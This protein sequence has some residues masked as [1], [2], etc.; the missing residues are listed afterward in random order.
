[1]A[2]SNGRKTTS[3]NKRTTGRNTTN[4]TARN[5]AKASTK[6]KSVSRKK[7]D[8]YQAAQDSALF[9][10]IGLIVLF[11]VMLLLFCCNFG[12]IGPVGNTVSGVMFGLFG[13][14]AYVAPVLLFLAVAFWFA[15]EG[16]PN[17][18]RKLI[19]GIVLFVMV[20]IV[21][22][23]IVGNAAEMATYNVAM[24]Y[25]G[26]ATNKNGGGIL[27]GSISY[28]LQMYL[29]TIGAVL[30]V[31]L[32]SVISLILLTEKSL[33]SSMKN[34]GARFCE[35]SREDAERRREYAEI[36]R[37]NA[38]IRRESARAKQDELRAKR[39]EER[40]TKEEERRLRQEEAENEKILRMEKKITGVMLD[41]ALVRPEDAGRRD[42]I[43]EIMYSEEEEVKQTDRHSVKPEGNAFDMDKVRIRSA[44]QLT[45]DEA[46]DAWNGQADVQEVSVQRAET[47][48]Q[49][50]HI[51]I[52]KEGVSEEVPATA[53]TR[54]RPV[55]R[56]TA[57]T[58]M[59]GAD[60]QVQKD[61]ASAEKKIP[62]TY[63]FP[64]LSRLQK[65]VAS[66]GD[67]T[68]ELKETAMR[69]QQTLHTFG[70]KVTITDI[71]QGPSVTRYELQPEQGVKVSKIVGL[72]DDIKLNL[73]A[74][75]IRIEAPIPGKAAIG[76]EVPNKENSPV[77]LRDLLETKEFKEFPSNIAFAVGKDIAGKTIVADIAKMPHMLIAGATGSGKSVCI[78]TLIM[79]ILYVSISAPF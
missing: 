60:A 7:Q 75:D 71:S 29:E 3:S 40:R 10:E 31:I 1:M 58:G 68:R 9:H 18:V 72:A 24:L 23:L 32:C 42:D 28:F 76:I 69:L 33:L 67:S 65:G 74:T 54:Q 45:I 5:S 44:H 27:G 37:E 52:H 64:P 46:D 19:S 55:A 8:A 78:N 16:N 2:T 6:A 13:W 34:G 61:I 21:C 30:V 20:G 11:A 56:V 41:T 57:T 25:E 62:K 50:Q 63:M 47:P 14:T 15:N 22:D 77:A 70:V 36:R 12:I 51:R 49:E 39:E 79:S 66:T 48:M 43:H 35:F 59:S 26:C 53:T 4:K 17:A 73:A 38:E